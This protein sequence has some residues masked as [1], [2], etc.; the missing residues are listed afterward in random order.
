[1]KSLTSASVSVLYFLWYRVTY[2]AQFGPRLLLLEGNVFT[3]VCQS[4]CPRGRGKVGYRSRGG[5]GYRSEG[6]G[7]GSGWGGG[8]G[9]GYG[10]GGG[11]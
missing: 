5:L 2:F 4:F 11:V 6:V 1:M 3:G 10:S 8:V 9:V 7:Y